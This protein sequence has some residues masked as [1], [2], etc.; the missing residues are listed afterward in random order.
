MSDSK[1]NSQALAFEKCLHFNACSQNFCPLDLE[2]ASRTG[3][4][5]DECRFMREPKLK[6]IA[7]REF[8]SGGT[9]ASDAILN[10]IPEKNLTRLN[11]SSQ[12]RWK[13]L[14]EINQN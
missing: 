9:V 6:K 10:F 14:N 8:M 5:R 13:K 12:E 7:G 4:T 1:E 3:G 2:L 11:Q